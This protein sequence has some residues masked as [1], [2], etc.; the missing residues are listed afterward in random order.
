MTALH[1]AAVNLL[2]M[3]LGGSEPRR[4]GKPVGHG[5]GLKDWPQPET[6]L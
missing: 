1:Y 3:K 6:I 5:E 2:G 4:D